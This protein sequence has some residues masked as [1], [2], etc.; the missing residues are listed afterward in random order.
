MSALCRHVTWR[1][2][3]IY[4]SK[5]KAPDR[6]LPC[7]QGKKKLKRFSFM[8]IY[9]IWFCALGPKRSSLGYLWEQKGRSRAGTYWY[10]EWRMVTRSEGDCNEPF[11]YTYAGMDCYS[12]PQRNF[13]WLAPNMWRTKNFLSKC[14]H[15]FWNKKQETL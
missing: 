6:K 7:T 3:D 8:I 11:L 2:V 10:H 12:T 13:I 14:S 9:Y 15:V 1:G 4:N 5:E